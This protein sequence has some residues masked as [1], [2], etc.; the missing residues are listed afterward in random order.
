MKEKGEALIEILESIFEGSDDAS[1]WDQANDAKNQG[2]YVD[3]TDHRFA[4][5]SE[6]SD[7]S[8]GA[9]KKIV[10][11]FMR[12]VDK[13]KSLRPDDYSLFIK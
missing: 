3:L 7:V 10:S 5:P 11:R 6:V 2:L 12:S 13:I 9:S 8:L 4:G 1:W